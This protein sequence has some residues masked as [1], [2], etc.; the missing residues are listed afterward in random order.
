MAVGPIHAPPELLGQLPEWKRV[1]RVKLYLEVRLL[2][3]GGE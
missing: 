3:V 1:A 2:A